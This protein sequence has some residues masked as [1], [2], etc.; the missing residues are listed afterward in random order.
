MTTIGVISPGH[1][2]SGLGWALR[3]GGERVVTTLAGRSPRSAA[4]ATAAGLEVLPDLKSVLELAQVVLVVTPPGEALKVADSMAAAAVDLPRG[5][6]VPLVADLNAIAPS[7]T[8]LVGSILASAGIELVDGSISGPPPIVKPGARLYF[9]GPRAE[10]VG[11]LAWQHVRPIVLGPSVGTASALK[12]CTASVYKGTIALYTQ[13]IRVAAAHGVVDAVLADLGDETVAYGMAVGASKAHRYVGEM[14][15]ISATQAD[16][17]L[18]ASLFAALAEVY[19]EIAT[20]PLAQTD[21]EA[22]APDISIA[23]VL[24]GLG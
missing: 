14:Q 6:P 5:V 19:A 1:M 9:S 24:R 4:L 12:M 10:E 7:T 11:G 23:E 21:A 13:A 20:H 22:V 8:A 18:P 16:A 3:E 2:G 17:G 15:E